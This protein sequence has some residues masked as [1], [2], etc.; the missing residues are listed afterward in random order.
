MIILWTQQRSSG[1][2]SERKKLSIGLPILSSKVSIYLAD[3]SHLASES[4]A[5][6]LRSSSRR[7]CSV[8]C[9]H[10]RFGDMFCCSWTMYLEQ[11]TCQS[12]RQ[13]SQLHRI[14]KTTENIHVSDGLWR[15]VT[16]WLLRLIN[17]LTD[18]YLPQRFIGVIVT[19]L[20][21]PKCNTVWLLNI[22]LERQ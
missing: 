16:F 9:V 14:Q 15:I 19:L 18:T 6:S 13:G 12:A 4:S 1:V 22:K 8:T 20:V 11:L 2:R 3:D 5:R 7:K 17:T 21:L 10:S